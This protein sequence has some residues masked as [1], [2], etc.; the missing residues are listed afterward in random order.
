MWPMSLMGGFVSG[1]SGF[2]ERGFLSNYPPDVVAVWNG[3]PVTKGD[4]LDNKRRRQA[5]RLA[6]IRANWEPV[7]RPCFIWVFFVEGFAYHGWWLYV[8]TLKKDWQIGG[9]SGRTNDGRTNG[10][11]VKIMEMFPC[12]VEPVMENFTAWKMAFAEAYHYPTR[13]R[14]EKQGMVIARAVVAESGRLLDVVE[15]RGGTPATARGI[16]GLDKGV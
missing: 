9:V 11:A 13:K 5:R 10:M 4:I 15:W 2:G 12:G 8:K 3:Q 1:F 7:V 14:P 6:F 16:T